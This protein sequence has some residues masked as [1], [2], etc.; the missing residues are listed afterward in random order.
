MRV[1][2]LE[3]R[4]D[5]FTLRIDRLDIGQ[6]QIIGLIGP[7]GCGKTTA[8]KLIAGLIR[9]NSGAIDYEG[10]TWRDITMVER[11]PYFLHDSVYRNLLYPLS[12][13]KISPD[14]AL[15][16]YYLEIA[17]LSDRRR[18]YAPRLSTGEQQK[19][20][21]VR[22]MIFSPKLILIDEA[23]SNLDIESV[24][25]FERLILERQNRE[26]VTWIIV[27][28]QLSNIQRLCQ[29]VCFM[30]NGSIE[31][32]GKTDEIL[33]HPETPLLRKY[34]HYATLSDSPERQ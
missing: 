9:P 34:L 7:N 16:D 23:F 17:G 28:H 15:V 24:E 3:K 27:S 5:G 29:R 2:D 33:F 20:S 21:L 12:L 14:P 13:R 26:P 11:K 25:R 31:A 8:M 19:L 30:H 22:A 4:F 10:L 6:G 18:Q 32:D 1:S